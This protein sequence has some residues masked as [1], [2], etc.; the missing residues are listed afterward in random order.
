MILNYILVLI[1][2]KNVAAGKH[3]RCSILQKEVQESPQRKNHSFSS[4]LLQMMV[5]R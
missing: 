1:K 3:F 2:A 4:E 5:N